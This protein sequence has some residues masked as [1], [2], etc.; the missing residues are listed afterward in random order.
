MNDYKG[1]DPMATDYQYEEEA[2]KTK[3]LQL[4]E[5]QE[6]IEELPEFA[7]I[8]DVLDLLEDMKKALRDSASKR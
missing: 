7:S 6:K 5:I 1:R 4:Y 3:L 8:A 2:R